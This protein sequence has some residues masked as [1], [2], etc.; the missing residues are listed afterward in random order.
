MKTKFLKSKSRIFRFSRIKNLCHQ[1]ESIANS[2]FSKE[3]SFE[4][5][6]KM[7]KSMKSQKYFNSFYLLPRE[8]YDVETVRK[9]KEEAD[10]KL[11]KAESK[12]IIYVRVFLSLAYK[13]L[14]PSI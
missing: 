2:V 11:A 12:N 6:I 3:S 13:F 5:V 7:I 1:I 14:I 4:N 10:T 8:T 9:M